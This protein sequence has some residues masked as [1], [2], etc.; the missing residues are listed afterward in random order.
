MSRFSYLQPRHTCLI[1]LL[2]VRSFIPRKFGI[3]SQTFATHPSTFIPFLHSCACSKISPALCA[4]CIGRS[5]LLKLHS[6]LPPSLNSQSARAHKREKDSSKKSTLLFCKYFFG[7]N[8]FIF[9]FSLFFPT[10]AHG[11]FSFSVR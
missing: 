10:L 2:Q 9:L 8:C 1:P 4:Y 6:T 5:R 3:H 11:C 7:E